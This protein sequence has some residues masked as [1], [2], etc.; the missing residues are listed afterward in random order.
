MASVFLVHPE[1]T[2]TVPISQAITKCSLFRNDLT[3]TSAPY[4]VQSPISLSIFRDFVSALEDKTINITST[5]FRGLQQLSDEFGFHKFATQLSTFCYSSLNFQSEQ[6]GSPLSRMRTSLLTESFQFLTNNSVIESDLSEAAALFPAVREQLSVD[7]CALK[8]FVKDSGL[9][10]A[11]IHSFQ[12]LFSNET[13]SIQRSHG[14]LNY[15]KGDIQL[16][17]SELMMKERITELSV[18]ALDSLLLSESVTIESEDSLLQF[19]LKLGPNYR[20]LLRH[21]QIEFLSENGFSILDSLLEIPPESVWECSVEQIAH[22]NFWHSRIIPDFPDILAEF[23][24]KRFKT[25]W[26]GS[27]DGFTTKEFHGRCDGHSNTLTVILDTKGNIFGG[28]TPVEWES[29]QLPC[30]KADN[31]LKSFVFTVKNP[32]N[33]KAKRFA[34][35]ASDQQQ[36]IYCDSERGPCFYDISVFDHCNENTL[37]WTYLGSSYRNDTGLDR[38]I[39]FTGSEYFQVKEI[40]VIEIMD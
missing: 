4:F 2:L 31:S 8:F 24:T 21:I 30:P 34:L 35:K 19:L 1:E 29:P 22:Q 9:E 32:H 16:N 27:R 28:F 13:I 10:S 33:I 12:L 14:L 23:G 18:E 15:S 39:F 40:E 37:S 25:L 36:A 11:D 38:R 17:L 26:R 20:D 3:L 6:I 5:N 7:G